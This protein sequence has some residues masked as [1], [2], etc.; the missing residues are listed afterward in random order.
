MKQKQNKSTRQYAITVRKKV[1]Q[2][3]LTAKEVPALVQNET[4]A[5]EHKM[6]DSDQSYTMDHEM[7]L[8]TTC[9]EKEDYSD[10]GVTS[11]DYSDEHHSLFWM[12]DTDK[13]STN[14][15]EFLRAMQACGTAAGEQFDK[16][17][18]CGELEA[19]SLLDVDNL[20]CNICVNEPSLDKVQYESKQGRPIFWRGIQ[21]LK[22]AIALIPPMVSDSLNSANSL[23]LTPHAMISKKET[24]LP[25][26]H[27][28]DCTLSRLPFSSHS[29]LLA[30]KGSSSPSQFNCSIPHSNHQL[31]RNTNCLNSSSCCSHNLTCDEVPLSVCLSKG[32]RKSQTKRSNIGK[33]PRFNAFEGYYREDVSLCGCYNDDTPLVKQGMV[34]DSVNCENDD[35]VNEHQRGNPLDCRDVDCYRKRLSACMCGRVATKYS[36]F[37]IKSRRHLCRSFHCVSF[38]RLHPRVSSPDDRKLH[39]L[40]HL[41]ILQKRRPSTLFEHL[42]QDLIINQLSPKLNFQEKNTDFNLAKCCLGSVHANRCRSCV[43]DHVVMDMVRWSTDRRK[44]NNWLTNLGS[45]RW[46]DQTVADTFACQTKL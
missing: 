13:E 19:D 25:S 16:S 28:C 35:L 6:D 36:T 46:Q 20:H 12:L 10:E 7:S 15:I 26:R 11:C 45:L 3:T 24:H 29:L 9:L 32:F 8:E 31:C 34:S 27:K 33:V 23:S 44:R 42:A 30:G 43:F 14:L 4:A 39:Y 17:S 38:S 37:Q 40:D 21:V 41:T 5:H 18:G 22:P 2:E 1:H